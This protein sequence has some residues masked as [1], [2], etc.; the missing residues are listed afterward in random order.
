MIADATTEESARFLIDFMCW[1]LL[2]AGIYLS[3]RVNR[4]M[5]FAIRFCF[6][7]GFCIS[8]LLVCLAA[9][10]SGLRFSADS[11]AGGA[12]VML[13]TDVSA[14]NGCIMEVASSDRTS[15]RYLISRI[16]PLR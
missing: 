13:S 4:K 3:R 2:L 16:S 6:R 14:I 12:D 9:T 11:A 1:L 7:G 15:N 8:G 10:G 5:S